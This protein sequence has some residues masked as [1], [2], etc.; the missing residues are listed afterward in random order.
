MRQAVGLF[1]QTSFAKFLLQG[2]D[3]E[4]VLQR[5]MANDVAVEPGTS[6]LHR[7]A[8][9][10]G[11]NRVGLDGKPY[12]GRHVHD[13]HVCGVGNPGLHLDEKAHSR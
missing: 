9:C 5:L 13:C 6:G 4:P 3:A 1:D 10:A 12:I 2:A 7:H 8:E 11:R